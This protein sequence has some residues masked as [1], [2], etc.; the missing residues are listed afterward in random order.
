MPR[1]RLPRVGGRLGVQGAAHKQHEE[2]SGKRGTGHEHGRP[3][4]GEMLSVAKRFSQLPHR[5]KKTVQSTVLRGGEEKRKLDEAPNLKDQKWSLN[6][7]LS[8]SEE[9]DGP[10]ATGFRSIRG[11]ANEPSLVGAD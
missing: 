6:L 7:Q 9:R 3:K 5:Q 1:Y 10:S 11:C 2:G 8:E 4:A